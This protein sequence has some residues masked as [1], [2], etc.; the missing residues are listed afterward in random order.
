MHT[1]VR[2]VFPS[3]IMFP[4]N[5]FVLSSSMKLAPT[6]VMAEWYG[7]SDLC[8]DGCV[9]CGFDHENCVLE[10]DT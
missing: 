2:L 1:K 6:S 4:V 3:K 10:Q 5:N 9:K 8:S 7:A